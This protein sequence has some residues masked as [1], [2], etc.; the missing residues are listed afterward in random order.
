[1]REWRLGAMTVAA[2]LLT[3]VLCAITM[4][5]PAQR[6]SAVAASY[7]RAAPALSTSVVADLGSGARCSQLVAAADD[8]YVLDTGSWHVRR[9]IMNGLPYAELFTQIMRWKEGDN[10]LIIG[11]PLD[12]FLTGERL[13]IL[14]GLGS[15]WGYWGPTYNR[16]LVPLRLQSNQ[17]APVAIAL[18]GDHLLWLDADK[19]Q[20]WSYAA[21]GSGYDTVPHALLPR[22][23][24][25]LGTATR[26]AV[27]HAA[28]LV[29][30]RG[31]AVTALPW[32]DPGAA[33]RL[34]GSMAVT[35]LWASAAHSRFY[36]TSAHDLAI[37]GPRGD[38]QWRAPVAGLRGQA[39]RDVAV[40]PR[41]KIYVLTGTR[42]LL[43]RGHV[44]AL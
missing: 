6:S 34:A 32:T 3:V 43:M 12:L 9:Y 10:G 25:A 40:S 31:G 29:L 30:G 16:A 15:L 11:K 26:L 17:G 1:M 24:P 5:A 41:G 42:I 23:L 2:R 4:L 27:S 36:A 37:V 7:R 33:T 21:S 8:L 44:P 20:V 35:G 22:P 19:R 18:H 38:A 13:F 28:L 14:D 39:L